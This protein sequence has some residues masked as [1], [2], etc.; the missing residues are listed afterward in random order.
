MCGLGNFFPA[1]SYGCM[2]EVVRA[3]VNRSKASK[4]VWGWC[5][6]Q[7]PARMSKDRWG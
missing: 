1:L 7:V 3:H 5:S 2:Y 6:A 4:L